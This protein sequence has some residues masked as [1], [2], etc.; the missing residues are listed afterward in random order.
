MQGKG[1]E[2]KDSKTSG[3]HFSLQVSCAVLECGTNYLLPAKKKKTP[4]QLYV[5]LGHLTAKLN[6]Q[7]ST[8]LH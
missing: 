8:G 4:G 5:V 1:G 2:K 6:I 7:S 3:I